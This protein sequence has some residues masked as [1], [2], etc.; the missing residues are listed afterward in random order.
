MYIE[1]E[2]GGRKRGLKFNLA[3]VEVF[4]KKIKA[5]TFEAANTVGI[6]ATFWCGLV[7]QAIRK[8]EDMD[9]TY[10]DV[11]DWVDELYDK[12]DE[13]KEVI[14]LVC[15]KWEE[16]HQYKDWLAEFQERIRTIMNAETNAEPVKKKKQIMSG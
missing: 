13:G 11:Q 2:L 10:E 6:Y 12:G 8:N 3:S 14:R 7:G 5:V 16:T 1:A 15:N 9:F 4:E